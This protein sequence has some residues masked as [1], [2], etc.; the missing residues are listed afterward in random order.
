MDAFVL[1]N[2]E[3]KFIAQASVPD[4]LHQRDGHTVLPIPWLRLSA[5][6]EK[7]R[8]HEVFLPCSDRLRIPR[9]ILQA[10]SITG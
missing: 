6:K 3:G 4:R 7:Q 1:D 5:L 9:E 10:E 2:L 8:R